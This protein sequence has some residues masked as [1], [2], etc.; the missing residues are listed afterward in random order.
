MRPEPR[1][2]AQ[3]HFGYSSYFKD[4]YSQELFTIGLGLDIAASNE[5]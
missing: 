1:S 3:A 4:D 5:T 2:K